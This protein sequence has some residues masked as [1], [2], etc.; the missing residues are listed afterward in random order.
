M[1]E[2]SLYRATQAVAAEVTTLES[3]LRTSAHDVPLELS[4]G[5][6]VTVCHDMASVID[7][8]DRHLPIREYARRAALAGLSII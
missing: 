7:S 1:S 2:R 8:H 3:I 4:D 5:T 6:T